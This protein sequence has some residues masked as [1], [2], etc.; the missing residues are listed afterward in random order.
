MT[1]DS[2]WGDEPVMAGAP[3]DAPEVNQAKPVKPAKKEPV[4]AGYDMEG[5][6]TDFPTAGELQKFVYDETGYSLNL[7]GRSNKL[8]YQIALD[9]LN[10]QEPA[11]EY[12]TTDNPYVD[13]ND[14]VP[15]EELKP[16]PD[17]DH[18]LPHR[19]NVQNS[20][21]TRQVPHPDEDCRAQDKYVEVTFRKYD[22]GAI[23]Y[24]VLGPI[25][26]RPVGEKIDKFGRTRPEL[27]RMID[28][29][30][31]EQIVQ[32]PNGELT[33]AGKKLRALMQSFRVNNSNYWDTW[34]DREFI[35]VDQQ[36]I[37]NPWAE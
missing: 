22:N 28:P 9:T 7:K 31:G 33:P 21:H 36:A 23:S 18:R 3:V 5:L 34:I 17:R 13:K 14:L 27:I 12:L 24:E 11:A 29:R 26:P 15:Q 19:D 35:S 2:V 20:F 6:M 25:E 8:K 37:L 30:T 1:K 10:G 4:D 16:V 32:M